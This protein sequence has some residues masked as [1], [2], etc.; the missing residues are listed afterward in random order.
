MGSN[1]TITITST[2]TAK[3]LRRNGQLTQLI[4]PVVRPALDAQL[5]NWFLG[6]FADNC[7]RQAIGSWRQ[8]IRQLD[9]ISN[10]DDRSGRQVGRF[11]EELWSEQLNFAGQPLVDGAVR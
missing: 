3:D 5:N 11:F 1:L 4:P 6:R 10:V 9:G 2:S 8:I 7:N